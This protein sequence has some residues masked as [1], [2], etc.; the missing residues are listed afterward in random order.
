[1]L[2][3]ESSGATCRQASTDAVPMRAPPPHL[4]SPALEVQA[5]LYCCIPVAKCCCQLLQLSRQHLYTPRQGCRG[6][7]QE[8][9]RA[10]ASGAVAAAAT[11]NRRGG[12]P[13]RRLLG[14]SAGDRTP[15]SWCRAA[16]PP[17]RRQRRAKSRPA[18]SWRDQPA[19]QP[20][21]RDVGA[22][23]Q[24]PSLR[25]AVVSHATPPAVPLRIAAG[26]GPVV[27]T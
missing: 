13:T 8:L 12:G 23:V 6:V 10:A 16:A 9:S 20:S 21:E 26:G 17:R 2:A 15:C 14:L 19:R 25:C 5:P 3:V 27:A 7:C 4:V 22:C 24:G 11:G 1:M 18:A